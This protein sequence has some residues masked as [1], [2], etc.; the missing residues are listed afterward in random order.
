M[1]KNTKLLIILVLILFASL[2]YV[3]VLDYGYFGIWKLQIQNFGTLQVLV[4]ILIALSLVSIWMWSD[5]KKTN[6]IFWPWV[7]LTITLGSFGPL[8]Y[9]LF[10]KSNQ[11]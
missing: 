10:K 8:L 5:A 7:F 2:T 4:D 11:K 3:A 6:R 9:L 1:H